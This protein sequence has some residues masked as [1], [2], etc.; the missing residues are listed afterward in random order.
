MSVE[1]N[2]NRE[3][4]SNEGRK[5]GSRKKGDINRRKGYDIKSH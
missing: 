2:R 3:A 1:N 5:K 4:K